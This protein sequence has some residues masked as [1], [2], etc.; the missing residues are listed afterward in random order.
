M[1]A[2][3]QQDPHAA[4]SF[5]PSL[6]EFLGDILGDGQG[7]RCIFD[8]KTKRDHWAP[9]NAG[10]AGLVETRLDQ[11]GIYFSTALFNDRSSR[12]AANVRSKRAF[13]LDI[14]AGPEKHARRAD[15]AYAT[16]SEAL[17]AL[18][19]ACKDVRIV[20]TYIV[21]SGAGLHVYFCLT[22]D[23]DVTRWRPL[24][25]ALEHKF[26]AAGLKVDTGVTTDRARV[27]RPIGTLHPSGERVKILRYTGMKYTAAELEPL[28]GAVAGGA[29]VL[30][31]TGGSPVRG[32]VRPLNAEVLDGPAEGITPHTIVELRS[33]LLYLASKGDGGAYEGWQRRAAQLAS[34]KGTEWE[35][36][37]RGLFVEYSAAAPNF[38]GEDATIKKWDQSACD[39]TGWRAIFKDAYALGWGAPRS[40]ADD[41]TS[42]GT[43][44]GAGAAQSATAEGESP[45]ACLA[46]MNACHFVAPDGAGRTV[47]WQES[48][49]PEMKTYRLTALKTGDFD[50]AHENEFVA[51]VGANGARRMVPAGTWWRRH[52]QR[53]Q[54]PGG[55]ALLPGEQAPAAVFNLWKGFG[56]EPRP[57]DV[58][59]IL[60]HIGI[61]CDGHDAAVSYVTK[62][63]AFGVQHPA[64]QTEVALVL[65]GGQGTGKGTLLRL[66]ARLFGSH[67]MH[68]TRQSHIVGNF[69][70]HLRHVLFL[71]VD[72]GFWAG[73]RSA[74]GVLK[75][76]VTEPSV[77][78]EGKGRD[79][80]SAVNR[81]K[82]AF[83]SNN[84]W[85]IP[86]GADERRYCVLDVPRTKAR[87]RAYFDRLHRWIDDGGAEAWLHHLL[88]VDLHGFHPRDV[89]PSS[90][91][92]KQKLES[93]S[94][95]D[96]WIAEALDQGTTLAGGGEWPEETSHVVCSAA[97][98]GFEDYGKRAGGR[99][100]QADAR[101]IGERLKS[102]FKCGP[103]RTT[104]SGAMRV[105]AWH[106]PGLTTARD[107]ASA[108][109]GLHSFKWGET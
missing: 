94:P 11:Q 29:Q 37:A 82:I 41:A 8:I 51:V 108:A 57:G 40:V 92:D 72:E 93:L 109:F 38:G 84:A 14:D 31:F 28:L 27:L 47:I 6:R 5:A 99:W 24:A 22:E 65:R 36:A 69:N 90:A 35:D 18:V 78:I 19:A 49:D 66:Q 61:L 25:Q 107:Q 81:L 71:F 104:A 21:S 103:S 39:R 67:G 34:M 23:L 98:R 13:Y 83:A 87:D 102:I 79:A 80:F 58:A 62:W 60:E 15:K 54:Y 64:R 10:L 88:H 16:Q 75:G 17:V 32:A 59:P 70:A 89:P 43:S 53:R 74:E 45:S 96:R 2:A 85:V 42:A 1:M 101:V 73:D 77:T 95:L 50:L 7:E 9:D 55:I 105:K 33:A 44:A 12:T 76:L 4:G 30:A 26:K 20:P 56:V 97:V 46:R 3:P 91:L 68:I 86:A 106:L 100:A 52:P 48:V 63:L